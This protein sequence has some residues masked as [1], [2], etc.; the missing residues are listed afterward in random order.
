[1][2]LRT[3]Q[4]PLDRQQSMFMGS[5]LEFLSDGRIS[6]E[7][8][9]VLIAHGKAELADLYAADAGTLLDIVH[10]RYPTANVDNEFQRALQVVLAQ[11]GPEQDTGR[12]I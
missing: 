10:Q 7:E 11:A 3:A 9:T 12:S 4:T 6:P 2:T 5:M 1:M 8:M